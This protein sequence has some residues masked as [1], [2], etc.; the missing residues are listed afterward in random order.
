ME[1]KNLRLI[2]E[3]HQ[4]NKFGFTEFPEIYEKYICEFRDIE[5]NL[6][7]IGVGGYSDPNDGG[8]SLRMWKDYFSRGHING[9]DFYDKTALE[10]NRIK[11]FKGSQ[12]DEI[13]LDEV[14]KQIGKPHIIIDDGSHVCSDV[15]TTFTFF[16]PKL[17][18]NGVYIIEDLGTSYWPQFGGGFGENTSMN[19]LKRLT[20]CLNHK[21]FLIQ[22]YEPNYFDHHITSIH[23]YRNVAI[24]C[25][26]DNTKES[27]SV[28][29]G[30]LKI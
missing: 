28:S 26:G 24:I 12:A 9:I 17:K 25:K 2:S 10:E 29:N 7:E 5:I 22:D 3:I 18:D 21:E 23:F 14:Y 1:R 16:F 19:F 30:R 27:L 11:I 6:L 8:H 13:F 4:V 15:I 20:D